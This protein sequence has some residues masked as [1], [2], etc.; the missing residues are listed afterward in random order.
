MT[1]VC[2]LHNHGS[3]P[4]TL[5]FEPEGTELALFPGDGATIEATGSPG[6]FTLAVHDGPFGTYVLIYPEGESD[7]TVRHGGRVVRSP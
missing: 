2:K 5:Q 6:L 4:L 3:T 7:Y 1:A